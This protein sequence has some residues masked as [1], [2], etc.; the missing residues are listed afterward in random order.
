MNESTTPS[1]PG[2]FKASFSSQSSSCVEVRFTEDEVLVR[3]SKYHGDPAFQPMIAIPAASWHRFLAIA[4]GDAT[5]DDAPLGIPAIEYDASTGHTALRDAVGTILD[6]TAAE[7]AAFTAG[8][9]VGEF[10]IGLT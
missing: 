2:W 4:T 6:Y 10:A 7:W 9:G 8:V 1:N 5:D 3:D